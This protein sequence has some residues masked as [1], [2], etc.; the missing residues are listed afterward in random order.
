[1]KSYLFL[2][3][4]FIFITCLALCQKNN[5]I[6]YVKVEQFKI[7]KVTLG[8]DLKSAE[9][10]FGRP[11]SIEDISSKLDSVEEQLYYFK[12]VT[13]L[14]SNNK[15]SR[16]ECTNTKYKTPQGIKVG[17]TLTKLFKTLGRTEIWKIENRKSVQYA[18]WP[19]CD[20]YMIFELD[21]GK[22]SKIVLDYIP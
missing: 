15:I 11:D 3:C 9:K 12:G 21:Q 14:V 6:A 16:L 5:S 2:F 17:D 22:I 13:A 1:M 19:P 8:S 18:L 20:T 7:A 4:C 10:L